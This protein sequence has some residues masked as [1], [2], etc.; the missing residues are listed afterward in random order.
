MFSSNVH[1]L[2]QWASSHYHLVG[3]AK[4]IRGSDVVRCGSIDKSVMQ[5]GSDAARDLQGHRTYARNVL[6]CRQ[7]A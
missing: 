6:T 2:I 1:V 7:A 4:N 5:L 3:T